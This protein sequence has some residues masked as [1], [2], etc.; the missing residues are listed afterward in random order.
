M[1]N[2]DKRRLLKA[3]WR[4]YERLQAARKAIEE[5]NHKRWMRAHYWQRETLQPIPLPDYPAYPNE[6]SD[7]V[8]GAQTRTGTPCRITL[9]YCNGRCRFHGGMSTGPRS[10]DGKARAALNGSA[11]KKSKPHGAL[12]KS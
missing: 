4:E 11:P 8:C 3:Y 7:M 12:N 6:L 9:I 1:T 2:D 5:A 10:K